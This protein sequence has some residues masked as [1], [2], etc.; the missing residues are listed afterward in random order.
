MP[1]NMQVSWLN[2]LISPSESVPCSSNQPATSSDTG[3]ADKPQLRAVIT[4]VSFPN[5]FLA[6]T[7][8]PEQPTAPRWR[9]GLWRTCPLGPPAGFCVGA[10]PCRAPCGVEGAAGGISVSALCHSERGL[11][12]QETT[13]GKHADLGGSYSN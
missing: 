9:G 10:L 8:S 11:P 1:R 5:P 6:P 7:L 4:L 13:L 12:A 2:T 3:Q